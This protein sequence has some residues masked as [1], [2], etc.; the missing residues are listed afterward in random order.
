M[1]ESRRWGDNR[2]CSTETSLSNSF[3]HVLLL[4]LHTSTHFDTFTLIALFPL[5]QPL[6]RN[7]ID[8]RFPKD[9]GELTPAQVP[10]NETSLLPPSQS[11]I[12]RARMS[13]RRETSRWCQ[14]PSI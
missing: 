12:E 10:R 13:A 3:V 14:I 6:Y 2:A 7:G 1:R 9:D 11:R 4:A 5:V 8:W